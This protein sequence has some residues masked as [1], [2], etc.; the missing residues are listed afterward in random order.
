MQSISIY[1]H[2]HFGCYHISARYGRSSRYGGRSWRSPVSTMAIKRHEQSTWKFKLLSIKH[3]QECTPHTC[4]NTMII[5]SH[6]DILRRFYEVPYVSFQ[7]PFYRW[8][9]LLWTNRD[10]KIAAGKNTISP[11]GTHLRS[12]MESARA[13]RWWSRLV[14][15]Y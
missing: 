9:L 13:M 11:I 4:N 10:R 5:L 1:I 3:G 8:L 14:C 12:T 7:L 15:N 6:S 2:T